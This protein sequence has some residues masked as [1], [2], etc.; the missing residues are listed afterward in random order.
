M[1]TTTTGMTA[2]YA[3]LYGTS[4]LEYAIARKNPNTYVLVFARAYGMASS[5]YVAILNAS[6]P[7][8]P[9][10]PL[11]TSGKPLIWIDADI[12]RDSRNLGPGGG[13]I[14][15]LLAAE[16]PVVRLT[17]RTRGMH[18]PEGGLRN[19]PEVEL[20][21][22]ADEL[23]QICRDCGAIELESDA[24]E[25]RRFQTV[26]GEGYIATYRCFQVCLP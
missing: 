24:K 16:T 22:N 7:D 19:V 25:G 18:M 15:S 26:S 11:S 20:L 14:T 8:T 21:L 1:P 12:D 9:A 6:T 13:V 10:L 23:A 3:P 5:R 17:G 2:F 4:S